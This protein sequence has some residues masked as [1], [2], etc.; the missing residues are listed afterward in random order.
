MS[1]LA[2]HAILWLQQGGT[3][4]PSHQELKGA[5]SL[6]PQQA[7]RLA[8]Y[9]PSL[10]PPEA[11]STRGWLHPRLAPPEAAPYFHNSPRLWMTVGKKRRLTCAEEDGLG[12]NFTLALLLLLRRGR[13]AC[14][15][16]AASS[17]SIVSGAGFLLTGSCP[18]ACLLTSPASS[19]DGAA[20]CDLRDSSTWPAGDTTCLCLCTCL[21]VR[22]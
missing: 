10:A 1:E 7:P 14:S 16:M 8:P 17:A 6:Q 20:A 22:L 19:G 9:R 11:G 15:V 5:S 13:L 3:C 4:L 2:I 18:C 12:L 21:S